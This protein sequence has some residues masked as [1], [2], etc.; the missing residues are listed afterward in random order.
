MTDKDE[1]KTVKR[2]VLVTGMYH[3]GRDHYRGAEIELTEDQAKRS[4]DL[5]HT[6][7]VGHLEK[8]AKERARLDE[9]AAE[10][11]AEAERQA[12]EDAHAREALARDQLN[13]DKADNRSEPNAASTD[14]PRVETRSGSTRRR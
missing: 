8:L 7:E 6:A 2:E 4:D 14:G 12:D 10:R 11:R 5:G 3:Q 9:E 13:P 1:P